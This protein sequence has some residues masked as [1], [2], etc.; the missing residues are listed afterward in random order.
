[1]I[2]SEKV[3]GNSRAEFLIERTGEQRPNILRAR[4]RHHGDHAE[5]E[6]VPATEVPS[7][8]LRLNRGGHGVPEMLPGSVDD[9]SAAPMHWQP[10]R[11]GFHPG[12]RLSWRR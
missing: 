8:A 6:L 10:R 2:R 1:M 4:D 9:E 11:A 7:G 3:H 5:Q 12:A